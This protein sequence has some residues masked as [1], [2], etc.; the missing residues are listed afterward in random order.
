MNNAYKVKNDFYWVGAVDWNLRDFHGYQTDK[1]TTYNA[2]LLMDESPVLFDTVKTGF[3]DEA[4]ERIASLIEP[5]KI[6][7][8]I[9]NHVEMDHSGTLPLFIDRIKPEKIYCSEKGKDALIKH[10]NRTDWNYHIVKSGD[11]I[12]TGKYT[13]SFIETPMLHWPDSMFS[14]IEG[15]NILISSDAFG[16]HLATGK[17]F[18]TEVDYKELVLQAGKYYANILLPYSSLVKKL[19]KSVQELGIKIDIIAPDHGLIWK[20]K[21]ADIITLYS[22]WSAPK[23]DNKAVLFYDTMWKSTEKMIRSVAEGLIDGGTEIRVMKLGEN[24]RSDIMTEML[25]AKGVVVGS[26]TLNNEMLPSVADVLTYAKGLKLT[27]RTG[28]AVNSYGWAPTV[29]KKI[30]GE[31]NAAGVELMDEGI[32]VNYVPKKEDLEKCYS[33][34][35]KL[36]ERLAKVL[37]VFALLALPSCF[38]SHSYKSESIY[39]FVNACIY[40][41]GAPSYCAC[42]MDLIQSKMTEKAFLEEGNNYINNQEFSAKYTKLMEEGRVKCMEPLQEQ[43]E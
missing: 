24:H 3:S 30:N 19:L 41:G 38:S 37:V 11:K 18:D 2:Y 20:D 1:G 6:K 7:Y 15:E 43:A 9:V 21:I 22:E 32:N 25:N 31:L 39:N 4:F 16:Q 35:K 42:V 40:N 13:I 36:S 10:F 12:K 17:R 27:A 8:I 23:L 29:L 26:S 28:F 5:E 34:G 14:Y 33:L